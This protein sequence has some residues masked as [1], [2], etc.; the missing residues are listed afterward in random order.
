MSE[1]A[2]DKTEEASEKKTQDALNQGDAPVSRD[3]TLTLSLAGALV[4]LYLVADGG[5][6]SIGLVLQIMFENA[7]S[8][9]LSNGAAAQQFIG[10]VGW[11]LMGRVVPIVAAA[12]GVAILGGL[13]QGR[14]RLVGKR[15]RP[16]PSRLSIAKGAERLFGRTA[17]IE[18]LKSIVKTGFALAVVA[19]AF[20]ANVDLVVL[21]PLRDVGATPIALWDM[22]RS[23]VF[24]LCL[25]MAGV[26]LLDLTLVRLRWRAKLRMTRQEVKDESKESEGDPLVKARLRAIASRRLRKRMIANV[27]KA[28]V[29]VA[30]PTHY[31]IAMRYVRDETPAPIV[32]AKGQELV[33]LRIREE[34]A[35]HGVPIVENPT[36]ARAMYDGVEIDRAIPV[37]FYR[38]IAEIVNFISTR[39]AAR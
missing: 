31:A 11:R 30:N 9:R 28:T 34:A 35:A 36:L 26:A 16:D 10:E 7:G 5:G 32:V 33:A 24:W 4:A 12:S 25:A 29:V 21:A 22:A 14:P 6:A 2:Q 18:F 27:A 19:M 15:I 3:A 13:L 1:N 23:I 20:A 8:F 38:A 37:E 39:G 17:W